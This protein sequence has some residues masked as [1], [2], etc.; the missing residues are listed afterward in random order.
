MRLTTALTCLLLSP[1]LHAQQCLSDLEIRNLE[2][3]AS[4]ITLDQYA[5]QVAA[6]DIR[7]AR[8]CQPLMTD[9][10]RAAMRAEMQNAARAR[11]PMTFIH[12]GGRTGIQSGGIQ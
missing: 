4:S 8:A 2:T 3:S 7:R 12:T 6:E 9:A 5:R 11:R 1:A 10:E